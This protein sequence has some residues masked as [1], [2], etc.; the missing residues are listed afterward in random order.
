M[1][2]DCGEGTLDQL[3]TFYGE[4]ET[5]HLLTKLEAIFISHN[6]T[7]HHLVGKTI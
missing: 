7:D 1:M 3:R 6:H 2:L 4:E 5:D